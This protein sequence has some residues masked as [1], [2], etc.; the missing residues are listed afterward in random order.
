MN[1][2]FSIGNTITEF[3]WFDW[4]AVV[5]AAVWLIAWIGVGAADLIAP[6]LYRTRPMYVRIQD[7]IHGRHGKTSD[8]VREIR[9][10]LD[11]VDYRIR[12]WRDERLLR[13]QEGSQFAE[14][15]SMN[16]TVAKRL[17][18][19]VRATVEACSPDE[20]RDLVLKVKSVVDGL[21]ESPEDR[22]DRRGSVLRLTIRRRKMLR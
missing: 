13:L 16:L 6:L 19:V 21:P 10:K 11:H 20:T 18:D 8:T 1:E 9:A 7:Y 3:A 2:R 4:I 14:D 12:G 5:I 15:E 22:H 17:G